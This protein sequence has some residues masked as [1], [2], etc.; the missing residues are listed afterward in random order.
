VG[1]GGVLHASDNP[2]TPAR[3]PFEAPA[4]PVRSTSF[5][6]TLFQEK[7]RHARPRPRA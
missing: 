7:D 2:A 5:V 1:L 4:N 3:A 6:Q